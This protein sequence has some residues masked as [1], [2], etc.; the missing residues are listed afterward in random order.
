MREADRAAA[1]RR[2]NGKASTG[3]QVLP[4]FRNPENFLGAQRFTMF[5]L[6]NWSLRYSEGFDLS[7]PRSGRRVFLAADFGV[8]IFQFSF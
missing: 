2:R 7:G 6:Q 8:K 3:R 5:E 4:A 1:D